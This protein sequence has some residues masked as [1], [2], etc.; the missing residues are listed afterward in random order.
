MLAGANRLMSLI[1][2]DD[3]GKGD[4]PEVRELLETERRRAPRTGMAKG[5]LGILA[6]RAD[7]FEQA[8]SLLEASLALQP[9][10]IGHLMTLANVYVCQG[11]DDSIDRLIDILSRVNGLAPEDDRLSTFLARLKAETGVDLEIAVRTRAIDCS[12]H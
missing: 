9:N 6:K 11:G 1:L 5:S 12:V 3:L 7:D 4:C 2:R 8:A 10:D